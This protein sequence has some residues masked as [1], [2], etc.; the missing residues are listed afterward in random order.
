MKK[1]KDSND[2][3]EVGIVVYSD[4]VSYVLPAAS[5]DYIFGCLIVI[6]V[7]WKYPANFSCTLILGNFP[8]NLTIMSHTLFILFVQLALENANANVL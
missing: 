2:D 5:P 8:F 4:L 6:S 7:L 3:V 1:V